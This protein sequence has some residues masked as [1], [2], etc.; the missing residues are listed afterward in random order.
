V[1][2]NY[3][4]YK[5]KNFTILGVS[6]DED[7]AAWLAAITKDKLAWKQVSDLKGWYSAAAKLYGVESIPYNLLLDPSGKIIA[8]D[9]RDEE[10]GV[11]LGELL[12]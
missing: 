11:K 5:N 12:K 1:V 2:A 8:T 6:L 10:L 7:K 4:K 9:L 3:N